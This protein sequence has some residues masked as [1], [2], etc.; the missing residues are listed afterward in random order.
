MTKYDVF[1]LGNALVDILA[2]VDDSF[3]AAKEL[4]KGSMTLVDAAQQ[5]A[6][7]ND[8]DG[9]DLQLRSGG[10]AANTMIAIAQSGG[11]GFYTGKV[12]KD[13]HG[14]FYRQDLIDAGI[15]FDV[16]P[17]KNEGPTGTSLILT[18]P[19]AERTMCTNLG[20]S[21]DLELEDIELD[22]IGD[23]KFV[24]VEGYLWDGEQP[25]AASQHTM[26]SAKS[27]G[28]PVS[29]TFS[30]MFLVDRFGDDFKRITQEFCDVIFCNA[31]EIRHF[32][33]LKSIEECAVQLGKLVETAFI[34]D[35]ANGCYVIRNGEVKQVAGFE[36]KAVDTV[37][38]GDAF[39]GGVLYGLTHDLDFADAA[40]W[41][42]YVASK[43][44]QVYGARLDGNLVDEVAK[45]IG[46]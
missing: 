8:L 45:I 17:S 38:A 27:K 6:L 12:A 24:Y 18:T 21:T 2:Q 13:S 29:F 25:R 39:A 42:N 37:G 3:I 41:G 22:R 1:G 16:N 31:D 9:Q 15:D 40:R 43:V 7:L 34:T 5:G 26:E 32:F 20:V 36:A 46:K 33:D 44:V 14:E 35:G 28:V 4:A 10:S 23:S 11:N 19:D 30:D